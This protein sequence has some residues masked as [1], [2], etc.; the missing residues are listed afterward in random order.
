MF[1]CVVDEMLL[2]VLLG[3]LY[4]WNK[5]HHGVLLTGI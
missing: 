4:V 5:T 1:T 2:I 3:M